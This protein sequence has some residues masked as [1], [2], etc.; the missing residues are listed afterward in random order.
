MNRIK[1]LREIIESIVKDFM[2]DFN[3]IPDYKEYKPEHLLGTTIRKE[4]NNE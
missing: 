1:I 3:K 2:A 4:N